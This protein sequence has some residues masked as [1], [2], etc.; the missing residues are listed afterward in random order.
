MSEHSTCFATPDHADASTPRP[1]VIAATIV[2][3]AGEIR[4]RRAGRGRPVLLL[5]SRASARASGALVLHYLAGRFRVIAP[6]LRPPPPDDGAHATAT[7]C[8]WIGR[9][10]DGLGLERPGIVA[11]EGFGL[12][13]L[14]FALLDPERVDRLVVISGDRMPPV[15]GEAAACDDGVGSRVPLL[16]LPLG[17]VAPARDLSLDAIAAMLKFLGPPGG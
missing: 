17:V 6:E 13:A 1:R 7:V 4:Y 5:T 3:G 12:A 10:A 9:V 2:T 11:D 8:D 15:A 16:L 14:R